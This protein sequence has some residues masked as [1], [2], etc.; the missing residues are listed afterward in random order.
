MNYRHFRFAYYY[1][2]N[3]RM[4]KK[5]VSKGQHAPGYSIREDDK[6]I[7]DVLIKEWLTR[8]SR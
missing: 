1:Q 5:K 8:R 7:P 4:E 6:K 2:K 3:D